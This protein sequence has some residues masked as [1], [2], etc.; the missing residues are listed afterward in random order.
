MSGNYN[1][2][3]LA[4][5]RHGLGTLGPCKLDHLAKLVLC[6]LERPC[7]HGVNVIPKSG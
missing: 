5:A 1:Y 6:V 4:V 3:G 2:N 7:F